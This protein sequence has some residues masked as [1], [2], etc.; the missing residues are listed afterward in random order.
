VLQHP[1]WRAPEEQEELLRLVIESQTTEG[2]L[3]GT[4]SER[5]YLLR[6]IDDALNKAWAVTP[7]EP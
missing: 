4:G 1:A 7:P 6:A 5:D 2:L 3:H